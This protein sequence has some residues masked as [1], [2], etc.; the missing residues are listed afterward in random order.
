MRYPG[1]ADSIRR[2]KSTSPHRLEQLERRDLLSVSDSLRITEMMYQPAPLA[3]SGFVADDFEYI[4]LMNV[5]PA[6]INLSGVQF[7]AGV[8]FSFTNS[9][10]TVLGPGERALVVNSVAGFQTRYGGG[11]RIAGEYGGQLSNSQE[12]VL[13]LDALGNIVLDFNYADHWHSA[14]NGDGFSLVVLD[15][16]SPSYAWGLPETW[17]GGL[18]EGGSPGTAEPTLQP[19]DI[20]INEILAHTDEVAGDMLELYNRTNRGI[21]ISGWWLSD[22]G[23]ELNRYRVSDGKFVPAGGYLVF[24]QDQHFGDA[25]DPNAIIEFGFSEL[26]EEVHIASWD[27]TGTTAQYLFSQ[28]FGASDRER[29]LGRHVRSDGSIVFVETAVATM[30]G[31]NSLPSVGPIVISEIMY[32]RPDTSTA[33]EFIELHN[34]SDVDVPLFLP[35]RPASRWE[36]QDALE[37]AFPANITLEAGGYLLI[38]ASN[39]AAFRAQYNVP[40]NVQVFGPYGGSLSDFG[41]G[42]T[43]TRPGDREVT[44]FIPDYVTDFVA[45]DDVAPWP[46]SANDGGYSLMRIDDRAF[47]NDV[48]NWKASDQIGG[49]PGR[50]NTAVIQPGDTSGD[51]RVDITDLNNVRNGFRSEGPS[52]V[53]DTNQD[54]RVDIQDLNAVRNYFG[55]DA[56]H[57]P[58]IAPLVASTAGQ[59]RVTVGLEAQSFWPTRDYVADMLATIRAE[60]T[61]LKKAK[62]LAWDEALLQVL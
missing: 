27:S 55:A 5:G 8:T 46:T 56:N 23:S 53:G 62:A 44:G 2:S 35:S 22:K 40:A 12:Q 47:G 26:G 43:L 61:P 57:A 21:N 18:L 37:F 51:G 29:T 19:G 3:G 31:P 39:G 54:G 48:V 10:V 60:R 49:T 38:V 52:V 34:I 24:N 7:A 1:F 33:G 11:F 15:A 41:E 45:Y 17:R 36:I 20:V 59:R 14:S 4:E 50:S 6:P 58:A 30:G 16:H 42:I 13:L 25:N 9:Q 28:E 32:N